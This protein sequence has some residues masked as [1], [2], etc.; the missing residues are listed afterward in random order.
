MKHNETKQTQITKNDTTKHEATHN[1]NKQSLKRGEG[2]PKYNLFC[3]RMIL[4]GAKILG[5][6]CI[7]YILN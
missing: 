4:A 2:I 3:R 1:N 6:I 7:L 5:N